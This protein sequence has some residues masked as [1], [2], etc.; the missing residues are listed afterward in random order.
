MNEYMVC[1]YVCVHVCQLGGGISV[2]VGRICV[3]IHMCVHEQVHGVVWCVCVCVCRSWVI[4]YCPPCL[5][6]FP[7]LMVTCSPMGKDIL[8]V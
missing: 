2:F 3:Y 7:T 4:C 8:S 1:M 6:D 5:A